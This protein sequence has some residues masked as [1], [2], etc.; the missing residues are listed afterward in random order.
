MEKKL[1]LSPKN[2][3]LAAARIGR[4]E[5]NF[6]FL[7]LNEMNLLQ[8][9]GGPRFRICCIPMPGGAMSSLITFNA[10]RTDDIS[11]LSRFQSS[12]HPMMKL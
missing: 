9:K 3:S 7:V 12:F 6:I 8:S 11:S 2:W 4:A 5:K 1:T 10:N